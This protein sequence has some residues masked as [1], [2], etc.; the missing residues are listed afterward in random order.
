MLGGCEFYIFLEIEEGRQ[1]KHVHVLGAKV[2][3][4]CCGS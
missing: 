2:D 1:L 3:A 4:Q